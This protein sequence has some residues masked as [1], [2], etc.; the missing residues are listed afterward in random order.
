MATQT[1]YLG[2]TKPAGTEPVSI[3]VLNNNFDKIDAGVLKAVRGMAAYNLLDNSD[4]RLANFIAQAGLNGNHGNNLYVGDRWAVTANISTN[5]TIDSDGLT[6]Y[7]Y[8]VYQKLSNVDKN[9]VYTFAA[10]RADGSAVAYY[11][12]FASGFGDTANGGIYAALEDGTGIPYV[13]IG[14]TDKKIKHAAL[15]EGAYTADTL[16]DYVPKGYAAELAECQRYFERMG[17]PSAGS[18]GSSILLAVSS[19][20]ELRVL[21]GYKQTKRILPTI[22]VNGAII[23]QEVTSRA[24]ATNVKATGTLNIWN[25]VYLDRLNTVNINGATTIAG[26]MYEAC[27]DICADL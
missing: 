9:K 25:N 26:T 23:G 17:S 8:G 15:Y 12:T 10:W 19:Y 4:F 21:Q 13:Q 22:I 11:G 16:P 20:G 24:T 3:D 1:K 14:W 7:S 6:T 18:Y 5:N 2:L 27:I